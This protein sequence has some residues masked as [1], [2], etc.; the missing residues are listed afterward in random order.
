MEKE[1]TDKRCPKCLEGNIEIQKWGNDDI[2]CTCSNPKC[3]FWE[4]MKKE[5]FEKLKEK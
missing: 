2:L 4:I 1:R 5:Q 3:D